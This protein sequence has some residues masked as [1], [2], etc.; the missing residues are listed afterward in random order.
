M[1]Q[2]GEMMSSCHP[3]HH[4]HRNLVLIRRLIGIGVDECQFVLGRRHLVM[5]GLGQNTNLPKFRIQLL[6]K[7]RH[8][9]LQLPEVMV[10]QFLPL[11]WLVAEE[12]TTGQ[13]QIFSL[14]VQILVQ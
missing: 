14:I 11:R 10:F 13:A 1:N 4:F 12:G 9:R 5:L 3:L 7:S 6:H 8:T 2:A